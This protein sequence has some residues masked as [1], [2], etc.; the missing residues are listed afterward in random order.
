MYY[1]LC[2]KINLFLSYHTFLTGLTFLLSSLV[3]IWR[4]ATNS[5]SDSIF[6]W[7][8]FF[9]VRHAFP[10][11]AISPH[12]AQPNPKVLWCVTS[13]LTLK[14]VKSQFSDKGNLNLS[15]DTIYRSDNDSAAQAAIILNKYLKAIT[16]FVWSKSGA[17]PVDSPD[18]DTS[19]K[20]I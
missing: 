9:W 13:H 20:L 4:W 8:S 6:I 19:R 11:F 17:A 10:S 2:S 15:G 1:N 3:S 7:L 16:T 18:K 12:P 14:A 5:Y